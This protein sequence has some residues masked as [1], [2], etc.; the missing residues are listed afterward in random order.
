MA[1]RSTEMFNLSFLDLLSGALGAVIFL[2]IITP[3]GGAYLTKHQQAVVYID[4]AQPSVWRPPHDSLTHK[5][6]R[7]TL[8]VFDR[9]FQKNAFHRRLS[10]VPLHP[11][12]VQFSGPVHLRRNA[13]NAQNVLK[14]KEGSNPS[15]IRKLIQLI[16][17]KNRTSYHLE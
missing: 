16:H 13:P 15:P 1:R 17:Q 12:F 3:K 7:D 5:G 9:R 10:S 4:V 2:F 14:Q 6:V 8:L 11:S